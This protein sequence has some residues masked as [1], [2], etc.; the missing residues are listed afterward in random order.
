MGGAQIKSGCCSK[1]KNGASVWKGNPSIKPIDNHIS[2]RAK[3]RNNT[4]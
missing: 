3:L 2:E 1:E 4:K